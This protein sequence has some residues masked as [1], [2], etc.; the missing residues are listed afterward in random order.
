MNWEVVGPLQPTLQLLTVLPASMPA[1][2]MRK[3]EASGA[4]AFSRAG[5]ESVSSERSACSFP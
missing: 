2:Q 3:T 1:C 4:L 5:I